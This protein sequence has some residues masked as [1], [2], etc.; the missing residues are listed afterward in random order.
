MAVGR[1]KVK[2]PKY[3]GCGK[4][5]HIKRDCQVTK[6]KM[7]AKEVHGADKAHGVHTNKWGSEDCNNDA[8]GLVM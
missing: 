5:S 6:K 3:Y 4:M 1:H 7:Q 8:D 2:G